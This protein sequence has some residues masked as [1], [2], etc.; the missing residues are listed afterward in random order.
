MI[1]F[2]DYFKERKKIRKDFEK[3]E[4]GRAIVNISIRDKEEVLSPYHYED[5]EII[6]EE[7]A[8]MLENIVK[9]VPLKQKVNLTIKCNNISESEK[10][11]FSV[12]TKNYYE[13]KIIDSQIRLKRAYSLFAVCIVLSII[14]LGLLFL[15][16]FYNAHEMLSE[17]VD[18]LVW[19]FVWESIDIIVFQQGT[20]R[21]EKLRYNALYE[22]KIN[23]N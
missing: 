22:S 14:S 10:E 23:F 5:K 3:D 8:S 4:E 20:I 19:V 13:N 11:E 6:N 1:K 21:L 16:H 2:V 7:F 9:S 17:V 15:T 12:A 18:I